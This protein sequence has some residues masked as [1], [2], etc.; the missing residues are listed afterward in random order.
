M[1]GY[2]ETAIFRRFG[3]LNMFNLLYM[4]AELMDLEAKFRV[5]VADDVKGI[6][7]KPDETREK[8]FA[9][10][11]KRFRESG[12]TINHDQLD[13]FNSIQGKLEKYN[14]ALLQAADV[15]R[16]NK[17][18]KDELG[19]FQGW[20][21]T[22]YEGKPFL[23]RSEV[24]T[25]DDENKLDFV[26]LL[27]PPVDDE[28]LIPWFSNVFL[29]TYHALFA[30]GSNKNKSYDEESGAVHY[31]DARLN[32]ANKF[33]IT[34]LASILP[35][36]AIIVLFA[37]RGTWRRI[38]VSIGFTTLFAISLATFSSARR[39]EIFAST[40]AFAAVEVVFIGSVGP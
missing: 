14:A 4:Q 36:V 32:R 19:F 33:L 27:T 7:E 11:F 17:P 37:V 39:L 24:R 13:A 35:I 23:K 40:A 1:G 16:L 2:S 12:A 5:L 28:P 38:Y 25:W 20:L 18:Q 31:S 26:T 3:Y 9:F 15:A 10:D 30:R 34:I 8:E 6:S 22:S 21:A 29:N